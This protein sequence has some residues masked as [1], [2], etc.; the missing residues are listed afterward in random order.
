MAVIS[1]REAVYFP[2]DPV[3]A[4][5]VLAEAADPGRFAA[6]EAPHLNIH[7]RFGDLVLASQSLLTAERA[8][9]FAYGSALMHRA[10]RLAGPAGFDKLPDLTVHALDRFARRTRLA[11]ESMD[12]FDTAVTVRHA[13]WPD[14]LLEGDLFAVL[15]G[16]DPE[17]ANI[18]AWEAGAA[19]AAAGLRRMAWTAQCGY[20]DE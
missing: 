4:Y 9:D 17:P 11:A 8:Q 13:M 7:Q 20:A 16:A 10:A 2:L 15:R 12:N 3:L 6:L 5:D 18:V 1:N 14:L 19:L